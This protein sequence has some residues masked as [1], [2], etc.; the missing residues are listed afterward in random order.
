MLYIHQEAGDNLDK[1][2]SWL[3]GGLCSD[4][5]RPRGSV[6]SINA[7]IIQKLLTCS[8]HVGLVVMV[9]V[10]MD[11]VHGYL[12]KR[13]VWMFHYLSSFYW[14][15]I[16]R[17]WSVATKNLSF[18]VR[19]ATCYLSHLHS[20][21]WN[22]LSLLLPEWRGW[23]PRSVIDAASMQHRQNITSDWHLNGW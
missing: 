13:C 3:L 14:L 18:G 21:R 6:N 5:W 4:A 15:Q 20:S 17:K 10:A 12:C 1:G 23:N 16:W 22:W 8:S 9:A 11:N 2:I 19:F 7:F